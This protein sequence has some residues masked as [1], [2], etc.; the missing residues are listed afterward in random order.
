MSDDIF[1]NKMHDIKRLSEKYHTARF[2]AF[3]DSRDQ[4]ILKN[5]IHDAIL[6]G[7]FNDAERVMYGVFPDW[8]EPNIEE[9]PISALKITSKFKKE[10]THRHFLGSLLSLGIERNKIGDILVA[11]DVTYVFVMSDIAEFI[12]NNITKIAGVGVTIEI[13]SIC[14][15]V[16]PEKKFELISA[17]CASQRLDAMISGLLNKSRNDVKNIILS[18][19]VLVNHFEITKIDFTPKINDLISI[20]GFGRVI[21]FEIGNKTRSDRVHITF[22]KFI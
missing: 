11:E 16:V 10:L 19:K 1:L 9:F 14:D 5:E 17:I 20:R 4:A 2:S 7:G 6:F 18:G 21:V 15:V 3:L 13:V 12:K 8:Q 22:K